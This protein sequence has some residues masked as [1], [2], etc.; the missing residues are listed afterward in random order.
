MND[1]QLTTVI[2]TANLRMVTVLNVLIVDD[3]AVIR[4]ILIRHLQQSGFGD[5]NPIEAGDGAEGLEK[6][7]PD[8]IDLILADWNMPNMNGLEF[9][10]KIRQIKTTNY[11]PIVMVTSEGTAA[12]VEEAF[13]AGVD[14]Y[15]A[16]PFT[17]E[18]I[19]S[20]IGA[21]FEDF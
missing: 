19:K 2:S 11:I 1:G 13:E 4:K 10:K 7:D 8:N 3:S 18:H 16:K 17:V 6:F 14:S 15:I 5:I 9:V 20:K 21:L 12:R